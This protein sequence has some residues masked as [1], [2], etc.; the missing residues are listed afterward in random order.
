M[1]APVELRTVITK[2]PNITDHESESDP[3]RRGRPPIAPER[4][5]AAADRLFAGAESPR[6]VT[7]DA[8]AAAAGVGKG[9]LFRAFGSRDVLLDTLWAQRLGA[10][11][12][13][14]ESDHPQ[15]GV[16]AAASVRAQAFLAALLDFKLANRHLIRAREMAP[17]LLQTAHYQWMHGLLK[18]LLGEASDVTAR[19]ADYR[20]HALL[21][22][23]HID[24]LEALMQQ[25]T[26]HDELRRQLADFAASVLVRPSK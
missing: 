6:Q 11:R 17:Q 1:E 3:P 25:G 22:S 23:L 26:T 10:L 12:A 19:V 15:L 5:L 24:L 7:M 21:A 16:G 8:I 2:N 20:A 4:L 13:R 9:T 18:Q 14:V